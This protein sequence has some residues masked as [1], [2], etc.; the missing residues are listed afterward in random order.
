V[1]TWHIPVA[2]LAGVTVTAGVLYGLDPARYADPLFHLVTGSTMLGAFFI[3][4]DPVS[5]SGTPRGKLIYAGLAGFITVI[6]RSYGNYPDGVAFSVLL[7]NM[8]VPFIDAHTQPRLF[9]EAR[10]GRRGP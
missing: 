2:F 7:M 5:A 9:G 1:I 10:S 4:T 8:A 3:L 6:I